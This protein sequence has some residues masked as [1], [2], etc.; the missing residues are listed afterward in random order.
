MKFAPKEEFNTNFLPLL[1][2]SLECG[3][4]KLQLLA[5]E[6]IQ[7]MF[8]KLDYATFKT[9]LLPRIIVVLETQQ[10]V[11]TKIKVLEFL[12]GMQES[13][14]LATMQNLVFKSFEKVRV[15]ENDP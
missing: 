4:P 14:D 10:D 5:L 8:K 12:K 1:Q 13:I 15:K 6:Q 7:T 2:K 9:V 3:V 11:P